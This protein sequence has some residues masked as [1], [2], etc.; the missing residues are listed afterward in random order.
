MPAEQMESARSAPTAV[1]AAPH[2]ANWNVWCDVQDKTLRHD[3][4]KEG[5]LQ[6]TE[7]TGSV[8]SA[9]ELRKLITKHFDA[10]NDMLPLGANVRVFRN[11]ILPLW[12]DRSNVRGGRWILA[13]TRKKT[14]VE[15]IVEV[16]DRCFKNDF[17]FC[18]GV[19]GVVLSS[20]RWGRLVSV[21]VRTCPS[22]AQQPA[23]E[24]AFKSFLSPRS[25][26]FWKHRELQST[27][28]NRWRR[29][30]LPSTGSCDSTPATSCTTTPASTPAAA[31]RHINLNTICDLAAA[32]RDSQPADSNS[33]T[34]GNT[35][36]MTPDS[37]QHVSVEMLIGPDVKKPTYTC[38]L[39][40][41]SHSEAEGKSASEAETKR[42]ESPD[43]HSDQD[44]S[45]ADVT[46]QPSTTQ[47]EQKQQSEK[48]ASQV[49]VVLEQPNPAKVHSSP[50]YVLPDGSLLHR[51]VLLL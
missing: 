41:E 47:P 28:F 26:S 9:E 20:R 35:P 43:S 17:D 50:L 19:T 24:A 7:K 37:R 36:V 29:S 5:F 12:E 3:T 38:K 30:V 6:H 1:V 39:S 42:A 51:C 40:M 18:G 11:G 34:E 13:F 32:A 10:D 4:D 48:L 45:S 27:H 15:E 21:W 25:L 33:T 8:G 16:V 44:K 46:S 2:E 49:E 14:G 31:N 22:K 23:T